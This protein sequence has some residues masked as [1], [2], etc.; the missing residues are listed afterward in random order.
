MEPIKTYKSVKQHQP[1]VPFSISRMEDIYAKRKGKADHPHRH[2]YYTII[3]TQEAKGQHIIDF[4]SYE[5]SSGQVFFVSPG[6]VHQIIESI[7]SKGYAM[8][9]TPDFLTANRIPQRFMD[10][11]NLF[12]DYG[13]CPAMEPNESELTQLLSYCHSIIQYEVSS[14]KYK[15]RAI[16]ALLELFLIACNNICTVPFENTQQVEAGN[17]ILRKFKHLVESNYK[18]WHASSKYAEELHITPDHLNRTIKSLI[19]KTAK[20][21]IQGRIIIAAKRMLHFSEFSLKEIG[22][23]LGFSEPA[24][25]S[26]FFKKH[27]GL[28]PSQFRK[29]R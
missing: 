8:T 14:A 28:S 27:T 11:L 19:G 7:P 21:Y 13:T 26:S 18:T 6:Q 5:L 10:D 29:N 1:E 4:N 12:H 16:A 25:F 20:E 17:T 22:Y 24:H 9:F 3:I 23:H 2:Q 15:E